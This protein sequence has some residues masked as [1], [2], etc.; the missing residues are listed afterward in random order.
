MKVTYPY[1]VRQNDGK[2][3]VSDHK[4]LRSAKKKAKRQNNLWNGKRHY[5]VVK[6]NNNTTFK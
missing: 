3:Y 5:I 6:N 1:S 4:T 2:E